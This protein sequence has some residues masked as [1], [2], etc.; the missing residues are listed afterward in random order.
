MPQF[1]KLNY[2]NVGREGTFE[3]TGQY[4]TTPADVDHLFQ[5][6]EQ[7]RPTRLTLHFHGGLIGEKAGYAIAEK[8]FG[9]YDGAGSHAVSFV[10]ETGLLETISERIASIGNTA[11]FRKVLSLVLK[12]SA[13]HL[14]LEIAGGRGAGSMTQPELDAELAKDRP[15]EHMDTPAA[16]GGA[17]ITTEA[18]L[19]AV[20]PEIEEELEGDIE[21]DP[22]L[23]AL[24]VAEADRLPSDVAEDLTTAGGRGIG[25][26]G[27]AKVLA[28]VTYRVIKRF[29]NDR[30]HGFYPT[31]VE[32]ILRELYIADLG[33]WVWGGMKTKAEQMWKPN[34]GLAGNRQHAGTYFLQALAQFVG[35]HPD[36]RIDVIGHSAGSIAIGYMLDAIEERHPELKFRN[37][38]LLAPACTSALFESKLQPRIGKRFSQFR[39]FTMHDDFETRDMLVKGIYT[40]SLL[41]FISGVLEDEVDK[42]IAGMQRYLS[43]KPP[44]T[45]QVFDSVRTFLANE[46][47]VVLSKTAD[48]AGSGLS[49][50]S[51]NH[52]F[53]DDDPITRTSLQH[54]IRQ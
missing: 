49:S 36:V 11:L 54:I 7:T 21:S 4:E 20:Q 15:F 13:K 44:Y 17:A 41:Y 12:R 9:V 26:L 14:G 5:T 45:G 48:G 28:K 37:L 35:R 47:H 43:G 25:L 10:W 29:V 23:Q 52:G 53:F 30:D 3:K 6:L 19:E 46:G 51:T 8:M 22:Q 32:E 40:R 1:G 18:E 2:I 31:V 34:A 39:M 24:L 50:H 16:R 27:V 42:A 38:V 33:A